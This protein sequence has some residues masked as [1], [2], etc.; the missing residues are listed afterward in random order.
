MK[1]VKKCITA[2]L[3]ALMLF[4]GVSFGFTNDNIAHADLGGDMCAG[5]PKCISGP[6]FSI[7]Q[8][9]FLWRNAIGT[10]MAGFAFANSYAMDMGLPVVNGRRYVQLFMGRVDLPLWLA[11]GWIDNNLLIPH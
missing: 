4:G 9:G 1:N 8:I 11:T 3:A 7:P 10:E 5:G 6:V 2:I